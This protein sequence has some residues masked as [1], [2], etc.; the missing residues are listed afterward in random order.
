MVLMVEQN[1]GE[2]LICRFSKRDNEQ[3]L[4]D[5]KIAI[6]MQQI[7]ELDFSQLQQDSP[8]E[9]AETKSNVWDNGSEDVNPVGRENPGFHEELYRVYVIEKEEGFVRKGGFSGE[10]DNIEDVV[11]VANDLCS[12]M[13]QTILSVD[14]EEDVNT[15]HPE[16]CRLQKKMY[17]YQDDGSEDVNSFGVGNHGFHDDYYDNLLLTKETE[18]EPIIWDIRDEE[19]EYPFVNKYPSFQE[20]SIVLVK[21]ESCSVYDTN[22]EEEEL[23]SIY[24]TDIEYVIEEEK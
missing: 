1:P 20:E 19:E 12:L 11:V 17:Y 24:D 14:F 16:L 9:E 2:H 7:L 3:D 8:T 4:C 13:I 18:S 15:N 10:E 21:E 6:I 23:M 5:V 22:N